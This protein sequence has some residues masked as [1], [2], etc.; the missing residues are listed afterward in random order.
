[1]VHGLAGGLETQRAGRADLLPP[2]RPQRYRPPGLVAMSLVTSGCGLLYALYRAYY[3]FGGT[4][5]MFGRPASQAGGP[6]ISPPRRCCSWSRCCDGCSGRHPEFRE[7]AGQVAFD[8]P[9]ADEEAGRDLPV[10][11]AGGHKLRDLELAPAQPERTRLAPPLSGHP[12]AES[13]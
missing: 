6:S 9:L 4:V 3:G 7:H 8:G 10:G 2:I 11:L 1:M 5:G 13:S 12:P